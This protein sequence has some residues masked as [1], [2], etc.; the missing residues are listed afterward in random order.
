M[1]LVIA[2]NISSFNIINSLQVVKLIE[3]RRIGD[4]IE[5]WFA[6]N[7][8]WILNSTLSITH[9]DCFQHMGSREGVAAKID[10]DTVQKIEKMSI[11]IQSNKVPIILDVL[12]LVYDI[13]PEVHKNWLLKM[14]AGAA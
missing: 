13:K 14:K 9:V 4:L 8:K 7:L 12:R 2:F 6:W 11:D 10:A 5:A 3:G 1:N